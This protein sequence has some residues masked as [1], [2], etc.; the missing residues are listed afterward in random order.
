MTMK[1]PPSIYA[2]SLLDAAGDRLETRFVKNFLMILR[3]NGDLAKL[4]E[5]LRQFERIYFKKQGITKVEVIAAR[6]SEKEIASLLRNHFG[7]KLVLDFTVRPEIDGGVILKINDEFVIDAS[8]K[9]QLDRL[10][11]KT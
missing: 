8:V 4:R 3:R 6:E 5:I 2:R 9:R 10:F 11:V 1:Q 7:P